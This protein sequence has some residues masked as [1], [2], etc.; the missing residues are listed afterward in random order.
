MALPWSLCK[1]APGWSVPMTGFFLSQRG[2]GRILLA[3]VFNS[4]PFRHLHV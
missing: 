1:D 4:P 2:L 3:I